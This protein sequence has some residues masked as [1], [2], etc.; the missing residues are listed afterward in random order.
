MVWLHILIF[1]TTYI[2]LLIFCVRIYFFSELASSKIE[3]SLRAYFFQFSC[4]LCG[5]TR[6]VTDKHTWRK[7]ASWLPITMDAKIM[8]LEGMRIT[9]LTWI[10]RMRKAHKMKKKTGPYFTRKFYTVCII[11]AGPFLWGLLNNFVQNHGTPKAMKFMSFSSTKVVKKVV[12][13]T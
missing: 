13:N 3:Q 1:F 2:K 9:Y 5:N 7:E 10:K 8:S 6:K 12:K 4:M 11:S